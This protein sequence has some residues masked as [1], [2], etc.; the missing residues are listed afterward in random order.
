MIRS[1]MRLTLSLHALDRC[2]EFGLHHADV[3]DIVRNAE[4]SWETKVDGRTIFA[5]GDYAVVVL[6]DS[7]IVITVLLWTEKPYAHLKVS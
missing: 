3:T 2:Q 1:E 4:V 6:P 5:K 7:G